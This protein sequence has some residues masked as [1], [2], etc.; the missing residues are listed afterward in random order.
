M[1]PIYAGTNNEVQFIE[2][3]GAAPRDPGT[4]T[5]LPQAE[6]DE[7]NA[8]ADKVAAETGAEVIQVPGVGDPIAQDPEAEKLA[9]EQAAQ[10]Q[11]A[12]AQGT[13]GK[14]F[15]QPRHL[16]PFDRLRRVETVLDR[17]LE[18]MGASSNSPI[19]RED[20]EEFREYL[21]NGNGDAEDDED[22]E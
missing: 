3:N 6:I 20:A 2:T 15:E 11:A 16:H 10:Q 9:A 14:G 12:A 21:K 8:Q 22:D 4:P 17:I 5:V 18:H 19:S 1:T 13:Y 7:L